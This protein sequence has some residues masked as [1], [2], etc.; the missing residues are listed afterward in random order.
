VGEYPPEKKSMK[1]KS[2]CGGNEEGGRQAGE[3]RLPSTGEKL[4]T[5]LL[6]IRDSTKAESC[7]AGSGDP[8]KGKS[9][10]SASQLGRGWGKRPGKGGLCEDF[11]KKKLIARE[12]TW[13]SVFTSAKKGLDIRGQAPLK[14]AS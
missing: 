14:K 8:S 13:E 5:V 3:N 12:K 4:G 6:A 1:G 2:I 9:E 10:D 7:V 11:R